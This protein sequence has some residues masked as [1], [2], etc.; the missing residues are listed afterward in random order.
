MARDVVPGGVPA[1]S[2][3][4]QRRP[5]RRDHRR[6]AD[7]GARELPAHRDIQA[8]GDRFANQAR[9]VIERAATKV[10]FEIDEI[11]PVHRQG[12]SVVARGTLH[13]VDSTV[14]D[15]RER[16][17]PEPWLLAE[18]DAWLVIQPFAITG[19]RLR[20]ADS[21][22]GLPPSRL[23]VDTDYRLTAVRPPCGARGPQSARRRMFRLG[24]V[25]CLIS[26]GSLGP[27]R[28]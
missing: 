14:A 27:L 21:G 2:S 12:W 20:T 25:G 19:R 10:A 24:L 15:F 6:L 9:K 7:R 3:R 16:F 26:V 1:L 18:R 22:L 17:D 23:R 8:D 28:R 4:S 5:D 11:D 13:P